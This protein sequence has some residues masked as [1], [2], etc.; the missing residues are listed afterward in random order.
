LV[1]DLD[2]G[3]AELVARYERAV[4]T[5]ALRVSGR[6]ID[7]EDLAAETLLR[8]YAALRAHSPE[9]IA[10]LDLR[11]WLIT[12]CL[13]QWRNLVRTAS[14]RPVQVPVETPTPTATA[15]TPED[16]AQQTKPESVSPS[17]S[18]SCRTSNASPSCSATWSDSPTPR[19]PASWRARTAPQ[20]PT[21]RVASI[22]CAP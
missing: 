16:H 18:N 14:R 22:A 19:S 21:C 11:P 1:R 4:F 2:A 6:A 9:R 8:A 13:N 3:F 7:A 10:D 20:N 17:S 15:E 12:I 5:T